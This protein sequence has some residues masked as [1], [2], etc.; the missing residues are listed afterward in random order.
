MIEGG[1]GGDRRLPLR[2]QPHRRRAPGTVPRRRS[3]CRAVQFHACTN[4]ILAD[5]AAAFRQLALRGGTAL[6]LRSRARAE[7]DRQRLARDRA[8]RSDLRQQSEGRRRGGAASID[9]SAG[10]P[11]GR[12]RQ[13]R[14]G[15]ARR[16]AGRRRDRGGA[17]S[18]RRERPRRSDRGRPRS[19]QRRHQSQPAAGRRPDRPGERCRRCR[20]SLDRPQGDPR[21]RGA[22]GRQPDH[23]HG[24]DQARDAP[25]SCRWSRSAT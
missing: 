4:G 2:L 16:S 3:F 6:R 8:L 10:L 11:P 1:V 13:A 9:R 22:Q 23:D 19:A 15:A 17:Q 14:S 12:Q 7:R 21:R 25:R 18:D 24:L 20:R 5:G